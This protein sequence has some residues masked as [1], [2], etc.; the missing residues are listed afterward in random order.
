MDKVKILLIALIVLLSLGGFVYGQ[1]LRGD[2]KK[3]LTQIAQLQKDPQ[4]VA[5]EEVAALVA[6]VGKL[7]VLPQNEQ[8]VVA[9]VTDV[10]KLKDQ[11]AFANAQNGD[12]I[13]IYTNEKKAYL[14]NPTKNVIVDVIPVNLGQNA[15]TISGVDAN[16]PLR[17]ALVNGSKNTGV[18]NTLA[19]RIA[20]AKIAGVS[21]VSKATAKTND[22][23][24]TIVIDLSGK[25]GSQA[26]QF[27]QLVGGEVATTSSETKPTNADLMVIIGADFK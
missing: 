20:D 24:K 27:A 5:N 6:K 26:A 21:V 9:T 8:P 10:T 11:P 7:V 4:A 19:T 17:V 23:L 18:T 1:K 14:Y 16:H 25:W 3:L 15:M 2:N 22:Y 13:L 12:K